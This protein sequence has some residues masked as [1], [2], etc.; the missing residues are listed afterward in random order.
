MTIWRD[1][2]RSQRSRSLIFLS[3]KSSPRCSRS[4]SSDRLV[5][6]DAATDGTPGGEEQT[7]AKMLND[8]FETAAVWL[9][10]NVDDQGLRDEECCLFMRTCFLSWVP[11]LLILYACTTTPRAP[12]SSG[13]SKSDSGRSDELPGLSACV[14][15]RLFHSPPLERWVSLASK[16]SRD[17]GSPESA[18]VVLQVFVSSTGA[19]GDVAV[20]QSSGD[21]QLDYSAV[22]VARTLQLSPAVENGVPVATCMRMPVVWQVKTPSHPPPRG[23]MVI[24]LN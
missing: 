10:R 21:P 2:Q 3:G 15:G 24:D 14:G 11:V 16:S 17:S 20:L 6:K 1:R 23:A 13:T 12:I 7:L 22:I 4:F 9:A 5:S 8:W 19:I 18:T